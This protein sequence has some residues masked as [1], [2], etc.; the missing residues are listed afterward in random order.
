MEYIIIVFL[1]FEILSFWITT[2]AVK[3]LSICFGFSFTWKLALGIW[4]VISILKSIVS[5]AKPTGGK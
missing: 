2:V 4:I 3:I 1:L 5:A